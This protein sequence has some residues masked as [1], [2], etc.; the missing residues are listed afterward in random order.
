[1]SPANEIGHP[2]VSAYDPRDIFILDHYYHRHYSSTTTQEL[3]YIGIAAFWRNLISLNLKK[4][5]S[6][7]LF[8]NESH[9]CLDTKGCFIILDLQ[10]DVNV[11]LYRLFAA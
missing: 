9:K 8:T 11:I 3:N 2:H 1:M 5:G 7:R 10:I 4:L 6:L